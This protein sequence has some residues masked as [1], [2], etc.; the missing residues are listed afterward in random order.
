[1]QALQGNNRI[2]KKGG[3]QRYHTHAKYVKLKALVLLP[4]VTDTD[5]KQGTSQHGPQVHTLQVSTWHQTGRTSWYTQGQGCHSEEPRNAGRNRPRGT[6]CNSTGTN[7]ES[8]AREGKLLA[9]TEVSLLKRT[10]A[11]CQPARL[12][13]ACSVPCLQR[14]LPEAWIVLTRSPV[15]WSREVITP[16]WPA[17]SGP[18]QDT[19]LPVKGEAVW[20]TEGTAQPASRDSFGSAKEQPHHHSWTGHQT[21]EAKLV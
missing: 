6:L 19:A 11:L 8:C 17:A 13:G 18:C 7:A 9:V 20:E 5:T 15:N 12:T 16:H 10:E 3:K 1:M 4:M 14:R 21:E 2:G